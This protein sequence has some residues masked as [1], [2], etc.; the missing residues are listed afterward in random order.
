MSTQT[1]KTPAWSSIADLQKMEL[2]ELRKGYEEVFGKVTKSRN[3][4][5]LY[6]LLARKL[7]ESP[8]PQEPDKSQESLSTAKFRPKR[9]RSKPSSRKRKGDQQPPRKRRSHP[10]G[11]ADPRLP[12]VGTIITKL[13]KGKKIHV[14]VLENGFDY[15][16]KH[17]RSLSAIA[18][19]VTGSIWNGFLFF[20]LT[21]RKTGEK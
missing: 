7:Q 3:R 14:K 19:E 20:G 6:T 17:Y 13:Y 21:E 16:G 5:H 11:A 18:R 12:K 15:S 8:G 2:K 9:K 4:K 10:L 1:Q